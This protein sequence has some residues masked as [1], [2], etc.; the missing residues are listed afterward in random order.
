MTWD[1]LVEGYGILAGSPAT[2]RSR[3][4]ELVAQAPIEYLLMFS[5]MGGP[6]IDDMRRSLRLFAEKV[7]PHFK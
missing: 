7:M 1:S 5:S 6:P 2:V 4:A 3:L